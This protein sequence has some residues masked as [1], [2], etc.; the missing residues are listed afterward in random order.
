MCSFLA[1]A[2][3]RFVVLAPEARMHLLLSLRLAKRQWDFDLEEK[4]RYQ[5]EMIGRLGLSRKEMLC[6]FATG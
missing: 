1:P 3:V 2:S 6:D 4:L 5:R